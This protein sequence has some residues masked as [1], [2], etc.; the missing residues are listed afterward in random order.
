MRTKATLVAA[1]VTAL[2][3]PAA[4]PGAPEAPPGVPAQPVDSNNMEWVANVPNIAGTNLDFIERVDSDGST[5]R[6]ALA[7]THGNGFDIVDVTDPEA[8]ST[9]GRYLSPMRAAGFNFHVWL[10]VNPTRD[11]VVLSVQEPGFNLTHG[12]TTGVEFVDISDVT[13]P[14]HLGQVAGLEGPRK[15]YTIGDNHVYTTVPTYIIDYS[16]PENPESLGRSSVCGLGFFEDPNNPGRTYAGE[17]GLGGPWSILDT[18]DPA[19]PTVITE[20]NDI[21]IATPNEVFPAPD[22]SFLGV[23]DLR[24]LTHSQC[25]GGGVH[26][27]DISGEY[28]AGASLESP[29]KMGTWFAPFG[30]ADVDRDSD[31][32]NWGPCTIHG[33]QFAPER[34]LVA[35]GL[36]T[37]G[38]WIMDPTEAPKH[39][40]GGGLYDEWDGEPGPGLGPTTW[41]NT[42]ANVL[43]E[44][45]A[46]TANWWL[47]FDVADPEGQRYVF[48]NGLARGLDVYRYTGPLPQKVARLQVDEQAVDGTVTGTLDRFAVLTHEGWVNKPLSGKEVTV[49]VDTGDAVTVL[50]DADGGFT[51]DLGLGPGSHEVT[52]TWPGDE[53]FQETSVVQTVS[54]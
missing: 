10:D 47:P 39:L 34:S 15:V 32:S 6:Y 12:G 46:V 37:G 44:G 5:K 30:G 49:E 29:K 27:Y 11:I 50:T 45:D 24:S 19:N 13:N 53:N 38:T 28:V 52:V 43:A 22:S 31:A 35:A 21:D 18:T 17:C 4:T 2:V 40:D 33:W 48:I 41:G 14:T 9:V 16:D 36:L 8:P 42:T 7:A 26:F 51:A 3:L 54:S 1:A 20:V 25:P 23:G